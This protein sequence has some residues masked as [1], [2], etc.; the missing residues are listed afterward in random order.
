MI[1]N[2]SEDAALSQLRTY[3]ATAELAFGS[4]LPPER[5]LSRELQVPRQ[6][7]RKALAVLEQE[8]QIWRQVGKG[9]FLGTRPLESNADVAAIVRR[10]NPSEVMR[11]RLLIEP[12]LAAEAAL[13]A[14]PDHI[15]EMRV[16]LRRARASTNWR[17]Y[18]NWDNRLHH[19][20]AK[21]TQNELLLALLDTINLVRRMVT[22]G[23][24]RRNPEGPPSNHHSFAE[25]EA[26]VDA[27]EDRDQ[28]RARRYMRFHLEHVERILLSPRASE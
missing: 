14:T 12:E 16:C 8:G 27:I 22:W 4:R 26:V 20:I 23:R 17:Q 1:E 18:E 19:A 28:E 5:Q 6:V 9:T 7:L 15:S 11:T 10:T 24:L 2:R 3:L 21:A 25:H 13:R